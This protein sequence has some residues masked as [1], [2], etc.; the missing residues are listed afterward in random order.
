MTDLEWVLEEVAL[1]LERARRNN[2]LYGLKMQ[3]LNILD[4]F[5]EVPEEDEEEASG[6]AA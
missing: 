5:P 3:L 4:Q 1:I 2:D 6:D